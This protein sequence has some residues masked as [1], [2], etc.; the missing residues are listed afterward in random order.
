MLCVAIFK[1]I[2]PVVM[3]NGFMCH[4][5]KKTH[6]YPSGVIYSDLGSTSLVLY[7]RFHPANANNKAQAIWSK[8]GQSK[9]ADV[10]CIYSNN[11]FCSPLDFVG[12]QQP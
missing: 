11:C 6:F 4:Y 2:Y 1:S 12:T 3:G 10:V 7:D 5:P 9:A 8:H